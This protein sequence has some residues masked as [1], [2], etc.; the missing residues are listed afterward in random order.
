M[1][2][3]YGW[4]SKC[5]A[6]QEWIYQMGV[7]HLPNRDKQPFYNVFVV[8][9]SNRYAAQGMYSFYL[10]HCSVHQE[11]LEQCWTT[12]FLCWQSMWFILRSNG[13][14]I[15]GLWCLNLLSTIFASWYMYS[16][17]QVYQRSYSQVRHIPPK[18]S[19]KCPT[20]LRVKL[21]K[22][23]Y[24]VGHFGL[25]RTWEWILKDF[26]LHFSRWICQIFCDRY[27][28]V[29]VLS[30]RCVESAGSKYPSVFLPCT[31]FAPGKVAPRSIF[32]TLGH[33]SRLMHRSTS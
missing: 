28:F 19:D 23:D 13:W 22:S 7:N 6:S 3:I 10:T 15:G 18:M 17:L 31:I 14:L 4:D 8:D 32:V 26:F 29:S 21:S 9:G 16:T 5:Q 25:G 27:V 2:V 33:N 30:F 20:N 1:C 24:L 12:C 11:H